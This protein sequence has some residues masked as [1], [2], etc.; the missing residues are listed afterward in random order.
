MLSDFDEAITLETFLA[1]ALA[2]GLAD[3]I[4]EER[5]N[6]PEAGRSLDAALRRAGDGAARRKRVKRQTQ[7]VA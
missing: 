4:E 7:E 5:R 3:A 6:T 2:D 1:A